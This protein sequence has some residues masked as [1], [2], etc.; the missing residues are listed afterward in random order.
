MDFSLFRSVWVCFATKFEV[1]YI[2]ERLFWRILGYIACRL[3]RPSI[4]VCLFEI[5]HFI[6]TNSLLTSSQNFT[7]QILFEFSELKCE[8]VYL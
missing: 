4:S 1:N 8:Y 2:V 3:K 6:P 7:R 5:Y